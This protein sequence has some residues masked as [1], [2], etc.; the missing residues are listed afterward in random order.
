MTLNE[1][2]IAR[3][4]STNPFID[5]TQN[6]WLWLRKSDAGH[7]FEKPDQAP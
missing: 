5:R 6:L 3:S 4:P 7:V 2:S 1:L